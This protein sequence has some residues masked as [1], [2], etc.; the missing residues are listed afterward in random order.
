VRAT[1]LA[2]LGGAAGLL[3][4]S[5]LPIQVRGAELALTLALWAPALAWLGAWSAHRGA[6]WVALGACAL[7]TLLQLGVCLLPGYF[8]R[9]GALVANRI[10]YELLVP[11]AAALATA[12]LLRRAPTKE[13]HGLA[14]RIRTMLPGL[15]VIALLF[16]WINVLI[17]NHFGDSPRLDFFDQR[18]PQ[19]DLT[20]SVAW[21][22]Y[23]LLL[24]LLGSARAAP[25]LRWAS[26]GLL[27][28]AIAKVFL[29]DLGHLEGLYRVGSLA[30]L[31]VSL[32]A[33]SLFYQR[34]VFRRAPA[35]T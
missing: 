31:A 23:A 13:A 20:A 6:P 24:L 29:L 21:G 25:A 26:L 17:L 10:S 33:V 18:L 30:G 15:C 14:A 4:A 9:S 27:L 35:A 28:L 22:G 32:F 2:W 12:W 34:F 16:A 11:A 5:A 7:A 3:V 19:R 8:A 1:A